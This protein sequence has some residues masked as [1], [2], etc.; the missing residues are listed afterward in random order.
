MTC[1]AVCAIVF[2]GALSPAVCA[3]EKDSTRTFHLRWQDL[4]GATR[5]HRVVLE[6]PSGIRLKGTV[7]AVEADALVMDIRGSSNKRA[8]PKGRAIVPRPE[9]TRLRISRTRHTWRA[10]GT[11]IG[12]GIGTLAAIGVAQAGSDRVAV[13]VLVA[14]AIP[15]GLGYALGWAADIDELEIVVE[16]DR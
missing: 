15:T 4:E 12:G 1:L 2:L 5:G 6:L 7:T 8:Y 16:P 9:V 14:V 11:A 3:A 13:N 10:V